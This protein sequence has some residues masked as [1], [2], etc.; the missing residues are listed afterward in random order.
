MVPAAGKDKGDTTPLLGQNAAANFSEAFRAIRTNVLF[1]TAKPGCRTLV[2]TSTA[3]G[4]GKTVT[5]ANLAIALAQAGQRVLLIDADMRRPRVHEL[6]KESQ[7]PGL[8][9][10]LVGNAKVSDAVHDG[11]LTG[12]SVLAGGHCPPNPS[13]LLGSR[14]FADLIRALERHFEWIIVDTPPVMAVTDACVVAH[15][16]EGVLFVVGAE[17]A[18]RQAIK[19]AIEQLER[20]DARFVGVVLNRVDLER[21][22]YYY[23]RYYHHSYSKYYQSATT[24]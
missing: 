15:L 20:V 22:A 19:A 14:R 8:S 9:N 23:S 17:M 21:N 2:V 4:E 3:P 18:G 13:E 11:P 10:V 6:F 24:Q 12:L 7:D 5:A 16:A 1:S